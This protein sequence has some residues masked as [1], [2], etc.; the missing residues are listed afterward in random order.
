MKETK[1]WLTLDI[2]DNLNAHEQQSF[3]MIDVPDQTE[4]HPNSPVF[5]GDFS[6]RALKLTSSFDEVDG[7]VYVIDISD[8]EMFA[9][10]RH[11]FGSIL[12]RISQLF[13][14]YFWCEHRMTFSESS[15]RQL[16]VLLVLNKSDLLDENEL[17]QVAI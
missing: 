5:F 8:G 9:Q 17:N 13:T 10:S 3:C 4:Y 15:L 2:V 11:C 14:F 6:C 1:T 7:L 12:K 16:P